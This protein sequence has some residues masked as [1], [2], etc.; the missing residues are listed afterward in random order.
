MQETKPATSP[1]DQLAD[2]VR[3]AEVKSRSHKL[4]D[5]IRHA[6]ERLRAADERLRGVERRAREVRPARQRELEKADA[7]EHNLKDLVRKLAQ[8]KATLESDHDVESL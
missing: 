2:L 1:L 5:E 8:L 7:D 3:Q 6:A 4:A